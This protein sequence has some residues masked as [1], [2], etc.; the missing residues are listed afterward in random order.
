MPPWNLD[1]SLSKSSLATYDECPRRW[2][3]QYLRYKL[4]FNLKREATYQRR[5]MSLY[6]LSGQLVDDLITA[7]LRLYCRK[8]KWPSSL[9]A[10]ARKLLDQYIEETRRWL[11]QHA[12]YIEDP[13]STRRQPVDE[14]YWN[15]MPHKEAKDAIVA[16]VV[17]LA[18]TFFDSE[19]PAMILERP[20]ETWRVP[21][22]DSEIPIFDLDGI[23]VYAKYDFAITTP[24]ETIIFDW[25]AGKLTS[26]TEADVVEQLHTYARYAFDVWGSTPENIRLFA[27]WLSVGASNCIHEVRYSP[28]LIEDLERHWREKHRMLT[29][30]IEAAGNNPIAL[31]E[32]F[33]MT[34]AIFRCATCRFRVC[35]GYS[36][37]KPAESNES[38]D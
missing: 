6:A 33:P 10:G 35:E 9:E 2:A 14:F 32:Q 13:D 12:L 21:E 24:S 7:S 31:L 20:L 26:K 27:V 5:L 19:V 16:E 8:Q 29:S 4:P 22:P 30:K 34:N 11:E 17:H 25:K 3:L 18:Q 23:K 15:G 37:A 1:I 36:R 38:H 28:E